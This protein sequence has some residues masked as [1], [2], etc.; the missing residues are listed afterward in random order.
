M[1]QVKVFSLGGIGAPCCCGGGCT[2]TI[3]ATFC[4]V[5]LAGASITVKSGSTTIASGTTDSTGC[6]A[7]TIPA[8]GTYT[9]DLNVAGLGSATHTANLTCGGSFGAGLAVPANLSL[10]DANGTW[11]MFNSGGLLLWQTCYTASVGGTLVPP[12]L[13]CNAPTAGGPCDIQYT[14]DCGISSSSPGVWTLLCEYG[15]CCFAGSP[16]FASN[17]MLN[18]ST[19]MGGF[20]NTSSTGQITQSV[21]SFPF[22][23]P[24]NPSTTMCGP[25]SLVGPPVGIPSIDI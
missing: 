14:L 25:N 21:I 3:C 17:G 10:T 9:I 2:T 6:L 1:A 12:H 22:S 19:C 4:G 15:A 8:A 18:T 7:V 23:I 11:S 20:F 24:L 13:G 16:T 5:N